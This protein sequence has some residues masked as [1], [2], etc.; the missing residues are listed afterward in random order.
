MREQIKMAEFL[1]RYP[2]KWHSYY[3]DRKTVEALCGLVNLGI[4]KHNGIGQMMLKS[5]DHAERWLNS[6]S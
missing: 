2:G 3:E 1:L 4:A 5:Q 6:K